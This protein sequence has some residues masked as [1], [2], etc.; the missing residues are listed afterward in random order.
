MRVHSWSEFAL[1][2]A[3]FSVGIALLRGNGV[4]GLFGVGWIAI[5]AVHL[6]RAF[7][8]AWCARTKEQEEKQRRA[9]RKRLGKWAWPVRLFGVGLAVL[10]VLFMLL[11]QK[12]LMRLALVFVLAGLWYT[13][14]VEAWLR[15]WAEQ[16][17][18]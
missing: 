11:P 13:M 18:L 5:G 15:G 8:K 17:E 2:A 6:W 12:Q 1:G 7:N 14:A 4:D 10:G 9:A 3:G 16:E